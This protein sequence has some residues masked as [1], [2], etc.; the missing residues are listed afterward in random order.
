MVD[1][2]GHLGMALIWL[3]VVWFVVSDRQSAIVFV[4]I[5]LPF[6]L[7]PDIDLYLRRVFPTIH[8]HGVVHTILVVSL[9][10]IVT[11]VILARTLVPWLADRGYITSDAFDDAYSLAIGAVLFA[12]YSH[13]F[14]D[15]LSAPDIS[16]P[17]EPFWPLYLQPV[18]ID[19]FYYTGFWA[20]WGL[21][22]LG[23]LVQGILYAAERS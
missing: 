6:G 18:S 3:G 12:G 2:A 13:L 22:G 20:T 16:Q 17:I 23:L 5:G 9:V 15:M 11:G 21:L 8:H 4:L 14:A 1:V 7:L 10:G 19:V